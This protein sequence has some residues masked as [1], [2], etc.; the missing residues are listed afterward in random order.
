MAQFFPQTRRRMVIDPVASLVL[1]TRAAEIQ[2]ACMFKA[3]RI[4]GKE[5]KGGKERKRFGFAMDKLVA[6]PPLH[7]VCRRVAPSR[8]DDAT[9]RYLEVPCST[10]QTQRV[11]VQRGT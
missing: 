11:Q 10:L 8:C 4:G 9:C 1:D 7:S 2:I 6:S 5:V 3:P